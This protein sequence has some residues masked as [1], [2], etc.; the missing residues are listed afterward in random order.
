[1]HDMI[2]IAMPVHSASVVYESSRIFFIV[3]IH[4]CKTRMSKMGLCWVGLKPNPGMYIYRYIYI[5]VYRYIYIYK[6]TMFGF[7][8]HGM[9]YQV[10]HSYPFVP[11]V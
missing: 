7:S 2:Y 6:T 1:M 9:D 3:A 8:W 5:H 4:Y 10:P 11:C